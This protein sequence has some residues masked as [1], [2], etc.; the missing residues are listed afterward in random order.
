MTFEARFEA[1][2]DA[3]EQRGLRRD[4]HPTEGRSVSSN[5][6]LGL[7][8][9][10]T[11][12]EVLRRALDEGLPT[13]STGSRLL[14]GHDRVLQA[15]EDQVAQWQ[16]A[17][18]ALLYSTGF[19]ANQGLLGA[20]LEPGDVVV[21]DALN[22]A[23]LIDAMRLTRAERRIVPHGDVDAVNRAIDPERP[24][25]V[26]VES[27]YSMDGDLAPLDDLASLC[28]D[29]TA[30]LIVDEAH[31][32]GMYG[33][34]GAGRIAELGLRDA[35]LAT[36]H[37]CG[38][39]LAAA[40]GFVVGSERLRDVQLQR[41]RSMIYSTAPSPLVVAALGAILDRIRNDAALRRRP[42]QLAARLRNRLTGLAD[43]IVG[44]GDSPIVPL[45]VG[46]VDR[47]LYLSERLSEQ[48]WDARAIRPPTVP[49]GA[50]R[51]RIVLRADLTDHDVDD[52]ADAVRVASTLR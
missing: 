31:A 28:A 3:L 2:L 21:S 36:V 13:G 33:P 6:Y 20:V 27:V 29:R 32:T 14:T 5:D 48:G 43:T 18:A 37:P 34:E 46:S 26:V 38:K 10:P 1:R 50:S 16:G 11:V 35:V 9:D 44:G 4:L 47:A 51:V 42:R 12:R 15:L 19:Q 25:V 40:G 24:T 22:H 8:G 7:S 41:A 52:L 17:E 30:A 23:S 45:I 39:A 49:E